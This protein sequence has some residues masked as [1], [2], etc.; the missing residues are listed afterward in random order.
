MKNIGTQKSPSTAPR[1]C[2]HCKRKTLL[3]ITCKCHLVVCFDCRHPEQHKCVFDYQKEYRE[4][5]E[6]DNP[7]IVSEKLEKI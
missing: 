4:K 1:G 5:L 2:Q 7:V 3:K 6:K